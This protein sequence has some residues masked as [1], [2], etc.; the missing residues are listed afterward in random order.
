MKALP[1][2][3]GEVLR[4]ESEDRLIATDLNFIKEA[5]ETICLERWLVH[6]K[7]IQNNTQ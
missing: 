7:L 1:D 4:I 2:D 6:T 3:R 5:S